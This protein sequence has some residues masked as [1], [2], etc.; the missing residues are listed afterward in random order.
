M[1]QQ[2]RPI[3][4]F[5]GLSGGLQSLVDIA[6]NRAFYTVTGIQGRSVIPSQCVGINRIEGHRLPLH[7]NLGS[8]LLGLPEVSATTAT[9]VLTSKTLIT[10]GIA[11]ALAAFTDCAFARATG[12]RTITA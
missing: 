7:L 4:G 10:P 1:G 5:M 12:G 11:L 8:R 2:R 9:P 3:F 6:F